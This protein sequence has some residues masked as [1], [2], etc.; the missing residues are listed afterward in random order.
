[1]KE[2]LYYD[3][4]NDLEKSVQCRLCPRNCIIKQN[5]TGFC[6]VRKNIDGKLYSLVYGRLSSAAVDPI[7]KKPFFHF[8]PESNAFSVGTVGCN[9]KCLYCQNWEISQADVDCEKLYRMSPGQIVEKA[10][11]NNCKII[12]YTYNDPIIFYEYV[13]DTAK[14]A[15]ERGIKNVAV[16]N[17]FISEEP[18]KKMM[19]H[20][21]AFNIDLKGFSDDF[22][23]GITTAWLEP[24][25]KTLKSLKGR[26]WLEITNLLIP[27]KNDDPSDIRKMCRWIR[28]NLGRDVPLHFSRFYPMHKLEA[29]PTSEEGLINARKIAMNSGLRYVYIGNISSEE[30]ENTFCHGCGKKLIERDGFLVT[31]NNAAGG[32]CECGERIPGFFS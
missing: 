28:E 2:V 20:I 30:G 12:A 14:I 19:D 31:S 9:L 26:S 4:R 21:D 5:L 22:Y 27:G 10:E 13:L 8:F 25:L 16:T 6:K 23:K 17:G 32:K 15:K 24:V 18:L 7:E 29:E 11:E 3:R 1:M